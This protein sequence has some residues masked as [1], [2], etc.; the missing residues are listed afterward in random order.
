MDCSETEDLILFTDSFKNSKE[1]KS[2]CPKLKNGICEIA[3]IE[4]E[5]VECADGV[6]CHR[7]PHEYEICKLYTVE[8]LICCKNLLNPA[9]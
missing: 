2:M 4:P 3:G 8:Y 1:E 6:F 9:A 7:T 5:H